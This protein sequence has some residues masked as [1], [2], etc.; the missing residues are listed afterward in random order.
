MDLIQVKPFLRWAGGKRQLLPKLYNFFPQSICDSQRIGC[1]IE[2]FLGGG[3]LY[4]W[5]VSRINLQN[6]VLIERN[7]VVVE[8]YQTVKSDVEALIHELRL[9]ERKYFK[10]S[11]EARRNYYYDVR[12][13]FN[14]VLLSGKN[15]LGVANIAKFIF[16]NKTCFNGLFRV[17][18][19]GEFNVPFG[20][21]R[22]VRLF[23]FDNL[24]AVSKVLK[25]AN[26]ICRDFGECVKFAGKDSFV[27]FDPPYRSIGKPRHS[28]IY[29]KDQFDDREQERLKNVFDALHRSGAFVLL[30]N[31]DPKNGSDDNYFDDLYSGYDIKRIQARRSI[32][33]K[34]DK[35]GRINEILVMNY[36][37]G[38]REKQPV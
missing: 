30:S 24:K 5:L 22:D 12:V 25:N 7:S 20:E 27:Y 23:D 21:P 8:C 15:H 32:N 6:V 3:A 29:S 31:S 16:L 28:R 38:T 17:N 33:C 10:M 11:L 9:K 4:F 13:A 18:Q 37:C 2:P 14:S 26:I 36:S 19:K 35:R 1:Y 34:V